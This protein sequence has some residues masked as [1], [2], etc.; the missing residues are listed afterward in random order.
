MFCSLIKSEVTL[1]LM[2]ER[3]QGM[4]IHKKVVEEIRFQMLGAAA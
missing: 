2:Q 4:H 1:G 3:V